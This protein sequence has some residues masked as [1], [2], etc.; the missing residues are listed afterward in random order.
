VLVI[1]KPQTTDLIQRLDARRD[2]AR[3]CTEI[4]EML[5]IE[6]ELTNRAA[7]MLQPCCGSLDTVK[8]CL[9][10]EVRLLQ[11]ALDDL[12]ENNPAGAAAWLRQFAACLDD[13]PR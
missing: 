5:R 6:T 10:G 7:D 9:V 1:S 12:N 11:Q 2:L 13:L 3:C 8:N 4:A